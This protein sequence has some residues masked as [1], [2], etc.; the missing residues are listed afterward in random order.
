MP[1]LKVVASVYTVYAQ[2]PRGANDRVDSC[3]TGPIFPGEGGF[4]DRDP[5]A[6]GSS[7]GTGD[8]RRHPRRPREGR[9][10]LIDPTGGVHRSCVRLRIRLRNTSDVA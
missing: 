5:G 1:L 6:Q 7:T 8:H 2:A 10:L 3:Q 4:S 9:P